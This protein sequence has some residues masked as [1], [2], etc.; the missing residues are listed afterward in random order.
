M[1]RFYT[2]FLVIYLCAGSVSA[3][4]VVATETTEAAEATETVETGEKAE[5]TETME[6]RW[7]ARKLAYT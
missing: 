5:T 4:T 3:F 1:P 7:E 2:A 6:T